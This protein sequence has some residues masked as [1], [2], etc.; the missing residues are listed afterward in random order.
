V[1]QRVFNAL[2]P[3]ATSV[4]LFQKQKRLFSEVEREN[5]RPDKKS[6]LREIIR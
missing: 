2:P 5:S 6:K 4:P 1:S 3:A